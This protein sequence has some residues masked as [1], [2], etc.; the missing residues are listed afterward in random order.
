MGFEK[1]Q[2]SAQNPKR[3]AFSFTE[4]RMFMMKIVRKSVFQPC[5]TYI[6]CRLDILVLYINFWRF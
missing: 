4:K 5:E 2:V 6:L 1:Y 3:L